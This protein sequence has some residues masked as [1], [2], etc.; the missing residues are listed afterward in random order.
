VGAVTELL[1]VVEAIGRRSDCAVLEPQAQPAVEHPLALPDDL[2]RFYEL[3]GGLVLFR[4]GATPWRIVPP[5][6]LVPA[7][8]RFLAVQDADAAMADPR[9]V[10]GT[11]FVFADQ[12]G[13]STDEHV[14]VDLHPARAGRYYETFWDRF[15]LAGEMPIIARSV[16]EALTWLL[17]M[18]GEGVEA[19]LS[20]RAPLGDAYD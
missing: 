6:E 5:G 19:A 20:R 15:G 7:A 4:D 2:R 11:T 17:E 1:T 3:C 14:V 12:G 10:A 13:A 8:R 18:R 16:A 9:D